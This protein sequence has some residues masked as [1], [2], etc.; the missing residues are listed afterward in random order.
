MTALTLVSHHLCPY[1]QRAAISLSEK[2]VDFERV[3]VDLGN[4]PDWF[5]A[6]SPL[7]KVP[8]LKVKNG[9]DDATIF[10]SAVI[11]EYLEETQPN[12]LHPQDALT[13]AR[14]RAWIEFGS[15]ILN[16]IWN[17]YTAK[18]DDD[19]AAEAQKLADMFKRVEDELSDGPYF[20]GQGFSLVDAVY[21]PIF[22]YFDVFDQ[23]ADFHV[24]D[25]LPKVKAWRE[26]L[27]KRNS[28]KNAVSEDYNDR[29]RTFLINR[30]SALSARINGG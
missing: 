23:I 3:Y 12:A 27:A 2:G 1:V 5:K 4:K 20:A 13:R 25:D 21:G 29:L 19:L 6:L 8:L 18:T 16:R 26:T 15:Q 7:G 17:F 28:I 14:H 22:R 9:N 10:E 30:N 11:L 24:F